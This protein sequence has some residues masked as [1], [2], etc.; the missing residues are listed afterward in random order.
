M[1]GQTIDCCF[2]NISC[3]L[4]VIFATLLPSSILHQL[5]WIEGSEYDGAKYHLQYYQLQSRAPRRSSSD[6]VQVCL[7]PNFIC[8]LSPMFYILEVED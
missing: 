2:V 6:V 8:I 5:P 1:E 4:L 7:H 3:P